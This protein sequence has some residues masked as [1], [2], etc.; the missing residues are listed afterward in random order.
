MTTWRRGARRW[1]IVAAIGALASVLVIA[2]AVR[3]SGEN[4]DR[5]TAVQRGARAGQGEPV[6]GGVPQVR[7]GR[8]ANQPSVVD[9]LRLAEKKIAALRLVGQGPDARDPSITELVE[10]C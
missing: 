1:P 2:L 3:G 10:E 7:G 6:G 9:F 8:A 5:G 4:R